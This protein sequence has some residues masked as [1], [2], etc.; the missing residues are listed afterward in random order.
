MNRLVP[1]SN[2]RRSHRRL[3]LLAAM[4]M[5]PH[6]DAS[7][8]FALPVPTDG[9]TQAASTSP[10]TL[11]A[12]QQKIAE[13]RQAIAGQDYQTAVESFR[14]VWAIQSKFPQL[15]GDLQAVRGQLENIGIDSALLTMPPRPPVARM[16]EIADAIPMEGFSAASALSDPKQEALRL[17]AIG[18]AALDRGDVT[19]ALAVARKAESM[20]VP[21]KDFAPGEPRVWQLVLDAESAGRRSGV[22]QVSGTMPLG[23]PSLVQPALAQNQANP[24]SQMLYAAEAG[25]SGVQQVQNIE[26]LAMAPAVNSRNATAS[27]LFDEGM[28][29][30]TSGDKS[31]A[32]VKFREAWKYEADLDLNQ[33]QLLKDKLT[34]LQPT[35]LGAPSQTAGSENGELSPISKAQ[36]ESQEKT[37]RLYREVTAELAKTEQDK[38]A[39]PLDAL[40]QLER[41]RRRV[42]DSD[43]D[44]TAKRSLAVMVGRAI[45]EQ[46]KY[47]TANRAKIDLDLQN[48]AVRMQMEQE[49]A[50]ES[51]I[52]HEIS[53]LVE[54]FNG[55]IKESRFEEAEVLAKQVQELKPEDPISISMLQRSRVGTRIRM[56]QEIQDDKAT[57]FLDSML[58][59]ERAAIAPDPNRP[60]TLPNAEDW[61]NLSRSRLRGRGDGDPR[62]SA[63]ENAIK[64]KLS[65]QVN[66]KYRDRPLGE[67]L[68]DLMAV[69]GVPIV[70]DERAL[71]VVRVTPESPVTLQLPNSISLNSALNIILDK[72]ELTHVIENDVLNITSKEAKRSKVYPVTYRVTD[73]VTPIPNF[74][75]SYDDGLA[76]ALR[77]AYQ[78]SNPRTDV[79]VV[80][81][82]MTDLGTGM[83]Q[84][85]SPMSMSGSN[86]LGQYNSMGSQG[87]F[88]M[89]NP[90]GGGGAGG[91][92]FANFDNLIELIQTTVVP[93]TWDTLGGPSTMREYAQNL[94]LVI[95]TTSDVH[96]Q[97]ADLL[98][99]LR[100]LQNL[101]ITIEVRFITLSDTFAEQ[102]GVDFNLS[103]D[104]NTKQIPDDDS[105]PSVTVGWDG[106]AIQPDLDIKLNNGSGGIVPTFGSTGVANPSTLGF[107]ILS[108]IEAFFFLQAIQSD[109]RTNV[110]QAPKVT[111]FDG[112]FASISDL[113]QRP[114]VTSITPV[115]G[116]FAVAQQPV[117]VVLNE[118]TQLNV[119]GLVSDDKRFVRLTL[120]PFFSQI[121][122]VN[123]FTYEGS[124]ST[125]RSS[126]T[127]S[128]DTNGDGVVDD[129]DSNDTTDETDVIEGTTVQLPTFA[130]TSVST[131]V[132]VPDGGTILLGGIKRMSEARQERGTPILSKIPYVSRLFRNTATSRTAQS[133]MLMV[134]PR[135]IIQEEEELAQTGFDPS[136][137]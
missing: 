47:I 9:A 48:D 99:S 128:G 43:I 64:D 136:Q 21:E 45:A 65:T 92:S 19:T 71:G 98:E 24:V 132:S 58:A 114:F 84:K 5:L 38:T 20:K 61:S 18:R 104:D 50:R 13:V 88:G 55:L 133:L 137:Q 62:L 31:A 49:D 107:A 72:M 83:A 3:A 14:A 96:D 77:N 57:G 35:R 67:V 28:K 25:G 82:S 36:L 106:S 27:K 54:E 124:R 90:P 108:D 56:G 123:T 79:Q 109:S 134:T 85:M 95:S 52:D 69:T 110:M 74:T 94:S 46:N 42:D 59:V 78:M 119:Q 105:G 33:R 121:G 100:R 40:D 1:K 17:V 113:T 102:I 44:D 15:A 12:G 70:I 2:R 103:F 131:T 91:A 11:A 53:N 97:I 112:Q 30:L 127:E 80:P 4:C 34:L 129:N 89:G 41:L 118:G 86:V 87:G 117:I 66:I 101:Q 111:L 135:I 73:L 10:S 115:V 16:P 26:P 8:Q 22:A 60:M 6:V 125:R 130:F 51:R 75:S 7:A 116:D 29:A 81:V 68:D 93:D 63:T 23:D 126:R 122:D 120:V 37:R 39:A 32:L 76:G